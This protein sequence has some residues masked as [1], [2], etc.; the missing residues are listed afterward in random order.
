MLKL[1]YSLNGL[2]VLFNCHQVCGY[3]FLFHVSVYSI[4][5]RLLFFHWPQLWYIV[6]LVCLRVTK[7]IAVLVFGSSQQLNKKGIVL[8]IW[9]E[10]IMP[11]EE[12]HK[13]NTTSR[14]HI[15]IGTKMHCGKHNKNKTGCKT[16]T[17][18]FGEHYKTFL[19]HVTGCV[20]VC[21][22]HRHLSTTTCLH[23][24]DVQFGRQTF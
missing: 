18:Q 8:S 5:C 4:R 17:R 6:L 19:Q 12:L 24:M 21:W 15:N 10:M 14:S 1:W 16:Q 7:N 11:L 23:H 3:I 20:T 13:K 9:S 2:H 22:C